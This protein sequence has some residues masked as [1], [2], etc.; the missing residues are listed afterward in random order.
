MKKILFG[1][2]V[3]AVLAAPAF[4]QSGM[5]NNGVHTGKTSVTRAAGDRAYAYAPGRAAAGWYGCD[6]V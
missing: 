4:A 5:Q 6:V 2:A 1:A 3:A